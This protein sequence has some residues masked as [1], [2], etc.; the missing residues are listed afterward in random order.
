MRGFI[1][2]KMRR[3]CAGGFTFRRGSSAHDATPSRPGGWDVAELCKLGGWWSRDNPACKTRIALSPRDSCRRQFRFAFAK[4]HHRFVG[5][6]RKLE[7]WPIET[8]CRH[9]RPPS[10]QSS[11]T[12]SRPGGWDVAELFKLGGRGSRDSVTFKENR[13]CPFAIV[14][15]TNS[16]PPSRRTFTPSSATFENSRP[17]RSRHPAVTPARRAYK[18]RPRPPARV[19]M[20]LHTR[21]TTTIVM[22][23]A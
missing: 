23:S 13:V 14:H 2:V 10:L 15:A 21:R 1:D 11:A 19:G 22:S 4:N 12:P 6:I 18:A 7:T 5:D 20:P 16:A 17:G 3:I 8:P 9:L